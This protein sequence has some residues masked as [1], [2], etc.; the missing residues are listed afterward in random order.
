MPSTDTVQSHYRALR[1]V[2]AKCHT[3]FLRDPGDEDEDAYYAID[4]VVGSGPSDVVEEF[5]ERIYS[6]WDCPS[7]FDFEVFI[8]ATLTEAEWW[9]RFHIEVEHEPTFRSIPTPSEGKVQADDR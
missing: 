9:Q 2:K 3:W 8:K 4:C 7:A 6:S 5:C 1:W